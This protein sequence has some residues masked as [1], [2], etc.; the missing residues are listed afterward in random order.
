MA[1]LLTLISGLF[2]LIGIIV[3]KFIKHKKELTIGAMGCAFV[4]IIGLIALDLIPELIEIKKWYSII[5]VVIGL[6]FLVLID[7]LIPHHHHNHKENDED[8]HEHQEHLEHIGFI[9]ILAL[10]L[11]NMV[12]GMALY[13]VS[14]NNLESGILMCL[15][16]GL[17]NLPFG[18]QIANYSNKTSNKL[19]TLLLVV[20]GL[21]GG[22]IIYSFGSISEFVTGIII[23][24]TLGMILYILFFE[25]LQEVWNNIKHNATF[26]GIIIGILILVLINLI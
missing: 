4:V 10:L 16:I 8:T 13:S 3:Y 6:V 1:L 15:G 14:V 12:E 20:S 11:H 23:A 2:F 21:I 26:C 5:F 17:H 7:K 24:L 19:A 25:L 18:F 9:T 22:L